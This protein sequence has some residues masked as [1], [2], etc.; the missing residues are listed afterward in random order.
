MKE[1]LNKEFKL[2]AHPTT[3]IFLLLSA[4]MLIPNYPY[5]ITFFY[6]TLGIY[7]T[8]LSSRENHDIFY[9]MSLPI[10]KK[11]IVKSKFIFV[12]L[13]E[14]IQ[15]IIAIPFAI[16]RKTY[17]LPNNIVGIEAN[18]AFFGLALIMLGIFNYIFF[19][20][21]YKNTDKVGVAFASATFGIGIFM[22]LAETSV[23]V[24]P[25]MR[26]NIDTMD[27]ECILEKL[28]ILLL[29]IILYTLLTLISYK[30]SVKNF[31]KLDL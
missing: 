18:I 12:I 20:K 15:I 19:I 3:F 24:I 29:G 11:D 31:E 28:I 7:F 14:F 30:R 16:I 22:V 23:N 25:Y 2:A 4:M 8:F 26:N 6:T 5:Y 13:I 10:R 9:T 21:Y 27:P 1:L 17:S